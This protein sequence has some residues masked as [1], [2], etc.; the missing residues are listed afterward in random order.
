VPERLRLFVAVVLRD[1]L[2]ARVDGLRLG[3][4]S[5]EIDRIPPHVT[6]VP[7]VNVA[8]ADL[9]ATCALLRTIAESTHPFGC[10][11]GPLRTF[12]RPSPVL[13]LAVDDQTGSLA[14]L[15][16]ACR[17]GNLAPP[18]REDRHGFV[19]HVT[20][21]NRSST[22]VAD[23][24]RLALGGLATALDVSELSLLRLDE[25]DDPE[26]RR[27]WVEIADFPLG[28]PVVRGRG[29]VEVRLTISRLVDPESVALL[30]GF[31]ASDPSS[32]RPWAVTARTADGSVAVASGSTAGETLRIDALVVAPEARGIGIGTRTL[33]HVEAMAVDRGHSDVIASVSTDVEARYFT[34][35][36]YLPI[37]TIA[38]GRSLLR[39]VVAR[40]I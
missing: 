19:P 6:L 8:G 12:D 4:G 22:E 36:G 35:R 11:L 18:A 37:G 10:G 33:Q 28:P 40:T 31:D 1:E 5:S 7:P 24:A 25:P 29:G 16:K 17:A 14:A 26:R 27:R 30:A 39:K 23:A 32:G 34:G 20:V 38:Q 15:A 13:Y 3:F 2:A 9:A 21:A